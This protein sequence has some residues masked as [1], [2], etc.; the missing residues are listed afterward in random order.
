MPLRN[1]LINSCCPAAQARIYR[2][3]AKAF[4]HLLGAPPS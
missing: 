2:R 1:E 4:H 3:Y